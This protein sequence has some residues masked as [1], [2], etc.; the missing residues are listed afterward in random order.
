MTVVSGGGD[1]GGYDATVSRRDEEGGEAEEIERA[2]GLNGKERNINHLRR[3]IH[4]K[5]KGALYVF[6][7]LWCYPVKIDQVA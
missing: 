4:L 2:I 7:G 1:L 6:C 3:C 5:F